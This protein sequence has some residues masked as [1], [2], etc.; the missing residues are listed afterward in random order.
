MIKLMFKNWLYNFFE[1]FLL[2]ISKIK[3]FLKKLITK[4]Q[5]CYICLYVYSGNEIF[6]VFHKLGT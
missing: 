3:N 6:Q 4:T 5:L 1:I 2:E